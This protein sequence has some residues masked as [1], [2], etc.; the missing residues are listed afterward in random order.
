MA[1]PKVREVFK[2]AFEELCKSVLRITEPAV[3]ESMGAR[4]YQNVYK[5]ICDAG[6]ASATAA[7]TF[8]LKD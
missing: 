6:R 1:M 5:H 2:A 4:S 8:E 7:A 3:V